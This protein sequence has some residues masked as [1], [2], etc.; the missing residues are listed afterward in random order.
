MEYS[1]WNRLSRGISALMHPF[2]IPTWAVLLMLY[3][4]TVMVNMPPRVKFFLLGIVALNT[5]LLPAFSIGVLRWF[6]VIPDWS[7]QDQKTRMLPMG[8][9]AVCYLLGIV[10]MSNMLFAFL[11]TRFLIAAL[12]CVA[13]AFFVNLYWKISLHMTAAGGLLGMLAVVCYAGL[14]NLQ[15]ALVGCLLL[16]GLLGSAR[17]R[18]GS[19]NLA[20]VAAGAGGGAV[21]SVVVILFSDFE[22]NAD[23]LSAFCMFG[24]RKKLIFVNN[25][26]NL[27]R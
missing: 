20:Q 16:A 10:A 19:H 25:T 9:V 14:A 13:F 24:F 8:I 1:V 11:I 2:V 26:I 7:L 27:T 12:C 22:K 3:G 6:R 21:I 18:L 23:R 17:L 4:P 15:Q 5:L